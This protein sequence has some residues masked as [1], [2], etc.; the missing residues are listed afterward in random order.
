MTVLDAS[1][2]IKWFVRDEPL[3]LEAAGVLDEI[4]RDPSSFL[5]PE[6]FMNELLA[7]LC[8]LP[9]SRPVR[10][11]EALHLVEALGLTRIGNG[12]Q[13]LSL[14]AEFADRWK[15]SGHDAVYVALAE[16]SQGVWLTADARAVRRIGRRGLV[17]L[18]GG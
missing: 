9:D 11:K 10:V 1:V 5:V 16:L 7:V 12:H 2:A 18:L 6:L 14:A 15:L 17:R 13:L 4:E 3:A 8:R